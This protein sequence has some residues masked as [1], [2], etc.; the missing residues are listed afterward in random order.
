MLR[1]AFT[2]TG[3]VLIPHVDTMYTGSLSDG[4]PK[5]HFLGLSLILN[6]QIVSKV[7]ERSL[8]WSLTFGN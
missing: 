7:F 2:L 3:L 8:I 6:F 1:M 5:V 4:M